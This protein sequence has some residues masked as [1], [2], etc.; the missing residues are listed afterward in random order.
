MLYPSHLFP[1]LGAIAFLISIAHQ[2]SVPTI[3]SEKVNPLIRSLGAGARRPVYLIAHRVLTSRGVDHALRNGANAI[4][5]DMTAF[6]E[7][8]WADHDHVEN[9]WGDSAEDLF[10]KI[11]K[12]RR[13]GNSI[14]FVWLDI[15][16]PDEY[17]PNDPERQHSSVRGLQDLARHI[18]QPVGVRV[19]YGYVLGANSKTYP[20]IRDRL[21][22]NEAINLD[23]NP[24]EA[25]ERFES[26][27]PTD[28]S[29]RVSSYGDIKFSFEFGDCKEE[30]YNTCTELRQAV[31]SEKF[32]MVF[33]WTSTKGDG[34]YV[35]KEL[36]TAGVDGIIYG[37]GTA[38]YVDGADTRAAAI[39]IMDWVKSHSDQRF[40]A[41]NKD[42][43]W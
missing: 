24:K 8:W 35:K 33:G 16:N 41:T 14:T 7:G 28:K 2:L 26:K 32:G 9:S 22:S 11:A 29:R 40:I 17:D 19:L 23:G 36:E 37:L 12:E 39:D 34:E 21:N 30:S 3:S 10:N 13:Y 6:K 20:F 15:K 27:G 38:D 4:E 5:M 25:L 43:P 31:D 18:L 42:I 1:L